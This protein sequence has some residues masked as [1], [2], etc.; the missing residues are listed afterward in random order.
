MRQFLLVG[1]AGSWGRRAKGNSLINMAFLPD[2]PL[3]RKPLYPELYW[4]GMRRRRDWLAP[5]W[6]SRKPG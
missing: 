6:E 4:P 3:L 5:M 1:Q 2:A